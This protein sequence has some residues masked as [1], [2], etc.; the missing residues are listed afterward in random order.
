MVTLFT[1]MNLFTCFFKKKLNNFVGFTTPV[2][3][4]LLIHIDRLVAA[5]PPT[6]LFT[7]LTD[8]WLTV[9]LLRWRW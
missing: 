1:Q 5:P 4:K 8:L 9:R 6:C 2:V 3:E 7:C